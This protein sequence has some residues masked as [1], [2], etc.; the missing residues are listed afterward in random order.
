[1]DHTLTFRT[2]SQ[3]LEQGFVDLAS[4]PAALAPWLA[5]YRE[6]ASDSV[7]VQGISNDLRQSAMRRVNPRFVLRNWIAEEVIRAVRDQA[8]S[9]PLATVF[10]LLR[11]PFDEPP[12]SE[13]YAGPP[14]EWACGLSVSC[15]S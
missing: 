7:N 2:L 5:R 11:A 10:D 12:G 9:T 8:D 4:D 1:M 13:R 15:S 3:P 6:A 14:P